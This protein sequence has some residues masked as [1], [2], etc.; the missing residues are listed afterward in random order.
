MPTMLGIITAG[1]QQ[2]LQLVT[3]LDVNKIFS[4][5]NKGGKG[6]GKDGMRE[7]HVNCPRGNCRC[8]YRLGDWQRM[9]ER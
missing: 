2:L 7:R 1:E 6:A 5:T 8:H 9:Y 4:A 3:Y